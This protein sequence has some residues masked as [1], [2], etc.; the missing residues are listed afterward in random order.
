[1]KKK[2][3]PVKSFK[4]NLKRMF[5][6]HS[7]VPAVE[8]MIVCVAILICV[9]GFFVTARNKA[10]NR[11]IAEETAY[12]LDSYGELLKELASS[13]DI[14][15]PMTSSTKRQVI[16]RKLYT[17]SV[18]TGYEAD[19]F[20][21]DDDYN[22]CVATREETPGNLGD[23]VKKRWAVLEQLK[24]NPELP[25][26][27]VET[28]G[29][30]KKIYL[31]HAVLDGGELRGY[32]AVTLS[33]REFNKLLTHTL[34]RNV[35]VDENG[36]VFAA[37]S[38]NLVD[39]VGRLERKIQ[40]RTGFF[41]YKNGSYYGTV[42]SLQNGALSIYTI[43]DNTDLLGVLITVLLTGLVV[44]AVVFCASLSSS[45]RM[46]VKSTEDIQ[47]INDAF[48][49]VTS[50]NLDAY[51]D[52][53]S[54]TEFENIGKCYNEMLDSLKHQ[55][56]ANRELAE[57]VAY[58]QVK[59]LQSQFNSHFLFNTLDNIRFMC[60]IDA[61]LAEFMT[62]S[63]SELLRYNTS[64]ANEKVTVE[65]DLDYIRIYLE[66]IKVRFCERFDYRI[67]IEDQVKESVMPK[68]LLQ[69]LIENAI[70]YGF[71]SREHLNVTVK[72]FKEGE[73]LVFLC[74]DDGVG[75]VPELLEKLRHNMTL[76]EN[77]SSHLGLYN[78][79]RRIKLMYGEAYGLEI[80]GGDGVKITVRLPLEYAFDGEKEEV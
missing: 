43:T 58:A 69:P 36:W 13:P 78:V 63:L 34:Q 40:G 6:I 61:D 64:N 19:L 71:G 21:L 51:L 12:T 47:K 74:R 14:I 30:D 15:D 28:R 37:G 75:I 60:K 29:S 1:M 26:V 38:Y 2:N 4:E 55:I 23:E 17:V 73:Q 32:V 45:E 54:S 53:R 56:A 8:L 49:S 11:Q 76:A 9:G 3:Q 72:G 67:E 65:E 57:T 68:L 35:M 66:I 22:V 80:E 70:K 20:I 5:L 41:R 79:H 16:V 48:L 33:S 25:A 44:L 39:E 7:L 27:R 52:I 24:Q 31:G 42:T 77:E 50:G 46:A 10:V 18:D 59:Q 62:V